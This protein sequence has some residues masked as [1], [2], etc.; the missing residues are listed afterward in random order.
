MLERRCVGRGA[1]GGTSSHRLGQRID[2]QKI[3]N[4]KYTTALDGCRS[5]IINATTN[6]KL[7][8]ATEGSMEGRCVK[9]EARGKCNYIVLWALDIK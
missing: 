2:R 7:T 3:Y 9:Q 4:I 8:A 6:Q 5:I 1:R